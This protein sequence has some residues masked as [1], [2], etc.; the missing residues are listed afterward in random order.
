MDLFNNIPT[1]LVMSLTHKTTGQTF[2]G[3]SCFKQL[4]ANLEQV[5]Q[6]S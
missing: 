3:T 6:P 1:F 4:S 2:T 5:T